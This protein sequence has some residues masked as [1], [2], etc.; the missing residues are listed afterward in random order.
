[1]SDN[2]YD[3][4]ES[5]K[6]T[7]SLLLQLP[8]PLAFTLFSLQYFPDYPLTRKAIED[9][10]IKIE[11][12]SVDSLMERATRNWAF[13]PNRLP[14]N[15][16]QML[17]NIIWLVV[18]EHVSDRIVKYAVFN[19][20][21]GSK[22]CINYMNYKALV[23]GTILGVGGIVWKHIWIRYLRNGFKYIL[24]GDIKSLYRKIRNVY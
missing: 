21:L 6:N 17:Q 14:F 19:N 11:D 18:F 3:T 16:K 12:A 10:H 9:G 15:K 8:K 2:P 4:E 22:F 7:I 23:L 13:V 24:K 5:L 1:M 20:S